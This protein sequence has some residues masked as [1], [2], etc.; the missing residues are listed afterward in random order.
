MKYDIGLNN[1]HVITYDGELLTGK[2]IYVKDGRIAKVSDRPLDDVKEVIDCSSYFVSP[3][4]VNLH[5]HSPMHIFR[6]IAEDVSPDAWFNEE[7]WPYESKLVE[8]DV[9]YGSMLAI[10]EMLNHGVT[11][12]ADHY[13]HAEML[14]KAVLD[15]GIRGDIAP[16]LF[17]MND[18]FDEQVEQVSQLIE[19]YNG[20]HGRLHMRMGPHSPYTCNDKQLKK[21][22]DRAK[23][24]QVGMHIHVSET[25]AQVK[26]CPY[27]ETPIKL[28]AELGGFDIPAILGHA[29]WIQ[30]E[31]LD[32]INDHVTIAA[33]PKTYMKLGM[34][35]GNLWKYYKALP[36]AVGTDGAASSNSIRPV[37]QAM[38]F[39]LIGKF[40]TS[41]PQMYTVKDMWKM[42]MKGHNALAFNSGHIE[43]GYAADLVVWDLGSVQTMPVY[44]PITS[45]LYSSNANNVLHTMVDGQFVKRDGQLRFN[46]GEVLR[47][48]KGRTK[49]IIGRGKGGTKLVF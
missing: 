19:T 9:Y 49:D 29:L 11:A 37:E 44:N 32:Y 10:L 15:T 40:M 33:C 24:L 25:E 36:L 6:G 4:L 21:V 47:E 42:L 5:A 30:E 8:E 41:N 31:D 20:N 22:F 27:S 39:G 26:D 46:Q 35:Y 28:I 23:D 3:G 14:A 2:Y 13:F 1:A 18:G 7:I 16:T 17:G 45:I 12:F 43:E 34:G 38:F 48:V